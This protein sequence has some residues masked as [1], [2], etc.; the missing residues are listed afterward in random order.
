MISIVGPRVN[1]YLGVVYP[2]CAYYV[3]WPVANDSSHLSLSKVI[4][5]V[6]S[7]YSSPIDCV[8]SFSSP[9]NG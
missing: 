1:A 6:P 4:L 2:S 8:A 3:A 9:S 7:L 5:G